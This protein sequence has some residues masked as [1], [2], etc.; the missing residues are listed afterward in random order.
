MGET[1]CAFIK[2]PI[3]DSVFLECH[4]DRVRNILNDSLNYAMDPIIGQRRW[5]STVP[6]R[7]QLASLGRCQ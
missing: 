3:R 4:C 7:K 2:I 5:F 6:F 1:V